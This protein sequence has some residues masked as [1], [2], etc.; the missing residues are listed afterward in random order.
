MT[1]YQIILLLIS[2]VVCV[3]LH[4]ASHA[5]VA[6]CLGDQTAKMQGRVS[7]N[8]ARHLDPLGTLMIFLVHFGWGKPV[9]FDYRNLSHPKRDAAIISLSGPL[10]NLL[11]ALVLG[12]ILKYASLPFFVADAFWWIY[13]LSIV[14]FLFNL[15]PIPPLDGS[16]LVGL[17]IPKSKESWY[18]HY[19]SQGPI[20][21]IL[22]IIVDRLTEQLFNF[23]FFEVY[24]SFI[25]DYI[26]TL[27]GLTS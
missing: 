21:L 18:W 12:V 13:S 22:F 15:L 4:E 9:Q 7:L 11:T 19:M 17:L 8:P 23:S 5:W 2:L 1:A 20:Y 27:I 16:K 6:S 3:T 26:S 24:L 10:A 25:S 14:L